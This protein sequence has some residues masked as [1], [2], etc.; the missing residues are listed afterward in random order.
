MNTRVKC[1]LAPGLWCDIYVLGKCGHKTYQYVRI[2][3]F[4][5][6]YIHDAVYPQDDE[7]DENVYIIPLR[8]NCTLSCVYFMLFSLMAYFKATLYLIDTLV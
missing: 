8:L 4:D 3:C 1:M 7:C 5:G 6:P 2:G